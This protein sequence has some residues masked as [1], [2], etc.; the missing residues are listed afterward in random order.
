MRPEGSDQ[1]DQRLG[2]QLEW[3]QREAAVGQRRQWIALRE[4]GVDEAEPGVVDAEDVD[5]VLHLAV[6]DPAEVGDDVRPVHRGVED[7]T[8][9]AAGAGRD[10]HVDA[11][12]DIA[13]DGRRALAGLVVGMRVHGEQPQ[14]SLGHLAILS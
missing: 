11:F 6:A 5:R 13:R 14:R 9:L 10:Q 3:L 2:G 12:G 8:A 4:T 1:P 7:R